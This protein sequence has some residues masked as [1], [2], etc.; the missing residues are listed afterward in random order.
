MGW[1]FWPEALEACI[2]RAHALADVPIMV[3]EN[4]V[5]IDDD[6]DR[7]E[8]VERALRGVLACLADRLPVL[9]YVYWSLL[10][11]F[12]WAFGYAPRSA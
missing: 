7:I 11:N 10:D 8:Y 3:T 1:E 12:E 9:G 4:G 5:A 6:R 2:R